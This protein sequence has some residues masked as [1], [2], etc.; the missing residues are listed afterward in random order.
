M[1]FNEL[2]QVLL[3]SIKNLGHSFFGK[4]QVYDRIGSDWGFNLKGRLQGFI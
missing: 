4:S 1:I 3:F 2:F